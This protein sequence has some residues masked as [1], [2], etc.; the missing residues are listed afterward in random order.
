MS[1]REM[2]CLYLNQFPQYKVIL[3]VPCDSNIYTTVSL[4]RPDML[5]MDP[6]YIHAYATSTISKI[7]TNVKD[8]RILVFSSWCSHNMVRQLIRAGVHAFVEKHSRLADFRNA[9]EAIG[10]NEVFYGSAIGSALRD[11]LSNKKTSLP[12][13][14]SLTPREAEILQLISTSHST[15]EAATI[16]GISPKTVENHRSNLMKK[17]HVRDIASLV[18]YSF[19]NGIMHLN[20]P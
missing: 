17:L 13:L 10:S 18:R 2:I 1:V 12:D 7:V 8:V 19:D 14:A 9:L 15:K 3:A 11:I 16:L 4:Y 20:E 6:A 5:I